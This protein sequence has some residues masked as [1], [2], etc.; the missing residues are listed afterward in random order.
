M[1]AVEGRSGGSN[2]DRAGN[3]GWWPH[4]PPPAPSEGEEELLEERSE[5]ATA[6]ED[7]ERRRL[8]RAATNTSIPPRPPPAGPPAT[9][10]RVRLALPKAPP[11]PRRAT[12]SPAPA[13]WTAMLRLQPSLS[14]SIAVPGKTRMGSG[15]NKIVRGKKR[16]CCSVAGPTQL[17]PPSNL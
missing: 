14:L 2:T 3:L 1:P 13:R 10:T 12:A 5:T 8:R 17:Y 4:I 6:G 16:R 15:Q 9:T 11:P 7:E